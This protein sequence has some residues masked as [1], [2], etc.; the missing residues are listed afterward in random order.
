MSD[1]KE[2]YQI[3]LSSSPRFVPEGYA[4]EISDATWSASTLKTKIEHHSVSGNR[5]RID[6]AQPEFTIFWNS[7]HY[8]AAVNPEHFEKDVLI[9][10]DSTQ[11]S[12]MF[13][14]SNKSTYQQ[15]QVAPKEF[16]FTNTICYFKTLD[17]L[18]QE[19]HKEDHLFYFVD[20]FNATL[21]KIMFSSLNKEGKLT[22]AF[23]IG[24]PVLSRTI[25]YEQRC[26]EFEASFSAQNKHFPKFVKTEMFK[27]L[28]PVKPGE[29]IVSLFDNLDAIMRSAQQNFELYLS[30]ISLDRFRTDYIEYKEKYFVQLRDILSKISTQVIALPL[31]I[32]AAAF[33]TYRTV[34]KLPLFV[35]VA[36]GFVLFSLYSFFLIRM[37]LYDVREIKRNFNND[38]E[39]LSREDYFLKY[40]V[41]LLSFEQVSDSVNSR[42]INLVRL[43]FTYSMLLA[44][45]NSMFIFFVL[46]QMGIAEHLVWKSAAAVF[47]I[48]CAFQYF[49]LWKSHVKTS[50]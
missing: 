34:D 39:K 37:Y 9:L 13:V 40:K 43:I 32:T 35:L 33:A 7:D 15:F 28:A 31:S 2:L 25:S 12:L 38:F 45:I 44:V 42:V 41:E 17:R 16:I 18:K 48:F 11:Q 23:P 49:L 1:L 6:L 50:S 3:I 14:A 10:N 4:I 24:A 27:A 21:R 30:D 47:L 20:Y 5:I 46:G 26:A 8:Y 29:R 22:I 36:C 19:E